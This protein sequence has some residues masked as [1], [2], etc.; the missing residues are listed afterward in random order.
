MKILVI[1]CG[2]SSVKY[3]LLDMD[4]EKVLAKGLCE[5]I[6]TKGGRF[7]YTPYHQGAV[8]W[9]K[10]IPD[11]KS[12]VEMVLRALS[13]EKYGVVNSIDAIKG[14][15]H[16][17][18]HGGEYISQSVIIDG[19]VKEVI[20][21]CTELAPLHN[22]ANLMGIKA[23]EELMPDIPMVGVFDTAFHQTIPA[24]AYLYGIP[25]K[26][27]EKYKIRKY[28]FHGIS[29][30]YVAARA[31]EILGRPLDNLKTVSC[32]LGNGASVCAIKNG[33]SVDTSMGFTP[34]AGLVMGTRCGDIDP[35]IAAYLMKKENLTVEELEDVL[36]KQSGVFGLSGISNDFRD[37]ENAQIKN[38]PQ[39]NLTM[40]VFSYSV[41]K[42]IA[43]YAMAM[44]G[45]DALIFTAGLGQNSYIVRQD[46]CTNLKSLGVEIDK[47]KNRYC[48]DA[49]IIS[50]QESQVCTMMIPTDEELA[51]A[52]ETKALLLNQKHCAGLAAV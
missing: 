24:Y 11:H 49:Q 25:Y 38:D 50:R 14:I 9:E 51:I 47:E 5:R 43:Q 12:A 27:Y 35:A 28:G 18:V 20:N 23:C 45:M 10:F 37:I 32:H 15:G 48:T 52:R 17:I 42:Y 26:L 36:N 6:G 29:H 21:I 34:L 31:A 8:V 44:D 41:S 22:P 16:R 3:Q 4:E 40:E 33:Q 46:I 13:H 39:A 19:K 30:K 1:N 2:S 7:K